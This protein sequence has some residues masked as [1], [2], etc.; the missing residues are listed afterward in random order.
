MDSENKRLNADAPATADSTTTDSANRARNRTIMLTPEM[1][2]QV[3][4]RL[5]APAGDEVSPMISAG[6]ENGQE[7]LQGVFRPGSW[8]PAP[9]PSTQVAAAEDD[10]DWTRPISTGEPDAPAIAPQT[11]NP[12]TTRNGQGSTASA[13][14]GPHYAPPPVGSEGDNSKSDASEYVVWR[15]MS[16]V[17]GFLVTFDNEEMGD[18]IELRQGRLIVTSEGENTG[19]FMCIRHRTVSPMHA[20][21]RIQ[22]GGDLQVLDQLS[23]SG[24][25]IIR[26]GSGDEELLSGEKGTVR[27]GDVVCFGERKYHVCL[28]GQV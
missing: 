8:Q 15:T 5:V 10:N 3:R 22:P 19:N 14:V 6:E 18:F 4:A 25:R 23:E 20:I 2:G 12:L 27:H 11:M 13:Q 28:L 24:T 9:P 17:S 7:D 21:M 16:P 26:A 1:T